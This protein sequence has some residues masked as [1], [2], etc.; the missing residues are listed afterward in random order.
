MNNTPENPKLY[1]EEWKLP[2]TVFNGEILKYYDARLDL[3]PAQL[4]LFG[5]HVEVREYDAKSVLVNRK[6]YLLPFDFKVRVVKRGGYAQSR[7]IRVD[8]FI[9]HP[10]YV[11]SFGIPVANVERLINY[12]EILYRRVEDE[13]QLEE[14]RIAAFR[15]KVLQTVT[16]MADDPYIDK[17]CKNFISNVSADIFCNYDLIIGIEYLMETPMIESGLLFSTDEQIEKSLVPE[18]VGRDK[19]E[20]PFSKINYDIAVDY[21][22]GDFE[23]LCKLFLAKYKFEDE[24]FA[25][26]FTYRLLDLKAELYFAE[27]WK[28]GYGDYFRDIETMSLDEAVQLYCSIQTIDHSNVSIVQ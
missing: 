5:H 24:T 28:T 20:Y 14:M 12:F 23:M 11:I 22:Y 4:I 15:D 18:M 8:I 25:K 3:S 7:N 2:H 19:E 6:I 26:L 13:K 10:D 21:Y 1:E 17:I 27:K 16:R 9:P